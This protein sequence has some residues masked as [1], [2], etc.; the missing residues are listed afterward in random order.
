MLATSYASLQDPL[1]THVEA[2]KGSRSFHGAIQAEDETVIFDVLAKRP[3][4]QALVSS[5]S[6]MFDVVSI[7]Q[8]LS[9][10][11]P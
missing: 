5:S 1:K 2:V 8:A 9:L 6:R 4:L 11:P 10:F 3:E 7:R